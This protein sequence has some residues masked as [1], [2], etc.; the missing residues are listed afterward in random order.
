MWVLVLSNKNNAPLRA[1]ASAGRPAAFGV[2]V[3]KADHMGTGK[4]FAAHVSN[5][6]C[7]PLLSMCE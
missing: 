3:V 2:L 6:M 4:S 7:G 5:K 1:L